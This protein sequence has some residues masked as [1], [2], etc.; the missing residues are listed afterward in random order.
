MKNLPEARVARLA[1]CHKEQK[2]G[3]NQHAS[4]L[5]CMPVRA[6]QHLRE[7]IDEKKRQRFQKEKK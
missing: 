2:A 1:E 6:I 7:V 5:D 4:L 3:Y